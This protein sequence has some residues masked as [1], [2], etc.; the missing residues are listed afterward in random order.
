MQKAYIRAV[1]YYLPASILDNQSLTKH[2]PE[3]SSEKILAK[4]GICERHI[5]AVDEFASDMAVQTA[6]KLL[7]SKV[8]EIDQV[9][10][11][12]FCTQ[13][14]DYLLPTSACIIQQRLGL[15]SSIGALDF[16]LGCSGFIY[17][18]SLAKGL[19]ESGQAHAVLLLTADTYT[20]LIEPSDK[21][22]RTLFGDGAAATLLVGVKSDTEAIFPVAYGTDGRGAE[23]LCVSGRGMRYSNSDMDPYLRMNG[24]EIFKF[25]L[26]VVPAVIESALHKASIAFDQIELFVFHQANAYMLE[27][28]RKKMNISHDKFWVA[29]DFC[30]NTV[31]SS[32]P[33]ALKEAQKAGILQHK[34]RVM[35]VGF[36]VGYSWG[37][38]VVDLSHWIF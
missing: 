16:N 36:G 31:S 20:K 18:L 37:A 19:I 13:T 22:V 30:G 21:S 24:P 11:L 32:I 25:T 5:S 3:F 2:F 8:I 10:F 17:G 23:N 29:M 14:P 26:D 35:L 33:I 7:A 34:K 27:H 1:E 9:D 4:T 28:L 15:P 38:T 12:L 6:R